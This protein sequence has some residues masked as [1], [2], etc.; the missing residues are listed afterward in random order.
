MLRKIF[1]GLWFAYFAYCLFFLISKRE[2][3]HWDFKMQYFSAK[4]LAEG[5]NPYNPEI[6]RTEIGTPLWYAYP[7]LTAWFYRLFN[8]LPYE[9]ANL[10]FFFI[11]VVILIFLLFFWSKHFLNQS[12]EPTFLFFCLL[13]FN[14]ALFLDLRSGNINL[15]EQ[16]L[17]WFGFYFFLKKKFLLFSVFILIAATFKG[18]PLFF[19]LL[20]L[21]TDCRKKYLFFINSIGLFLGYLLL[22][23][24]LWPEMFRAYLEAAQKTLVERRII[25]PTTIGLIYEIFDLLARRRAIVVNQEWQIALFIV[26]AT[27]VLILSFKA[28]IILIRFGHENKE[29]LLL[30]GLCFVYALI[31]LRMKD[32]AYVLLLV[33]SYFIIKNTSYQKIFPFL[34]VISILTAAKNVTLPDLGSVYL[35]IWEYYPLLLAYLMWG[36]YLRE[37][38]ILKKP[39]ITDRAFP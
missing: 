35:V 17:L 3:Y 38:F 15:F 4:L 26:I 31:T 12:L 14:S 20:L 16:L 28:Y 22:Q 29:K 32:Y 18:T 23:Y 7:P 39:L 25:C 10:L 8:L 5:K 19:L 27:I 11:K 1:I 33:P 37:I 9:T 21:T 6:T 36:L 13:A 34:F 30:F 2:E 24:A